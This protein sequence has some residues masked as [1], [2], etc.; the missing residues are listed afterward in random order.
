MPTMSSDITHN[1][2]YVPQFY[3][4]NW[5]SDS[6]HIYEYSLLVPDSRIPY[7]KPSAIRYTAKWNDFYTRVVGDREADDFEKWFN[8]TFENPSKPVFQKILNGEQI[9]REE[10]TI[11]SRYIA[12]QYLRTPAR[13][14]KIITMLQEIMPGILKEVHAKL[15]SAYIPKNDSAPMEYSELLPLSVS[16]D[17]VKRTITTG[18]VIGKSMY[19]YALKHLLTTTLHVMDNY[20]WQVVHAADGISF[21]TSDDPVICLNYFSENEYDF[22]G[23]WGRQHTNIIMPISPEILVFTEVGSYSHAN[24]LDYS[25]QWSRFFRKIIIEHAHRYV[26]A[27]AP[28]KG[29][30]SIHP[31][32]VDRT[33]YL[34]EQEKL[35]NWHH[36][37]LDAE[38]E[39]KRNSSNIQQK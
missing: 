4:Q 14:T 37:Q 25:T 38:L 2:H 22:G 39:L 5:S 35:A 1:N 18:T 19:L 20:S 29:M 21:P 16:I 3:L 23:G 7:W 36:D 24:N 10:S 31:R 6:V 11:L 26:Y 13:A 17:R 28:Q 12:A 8:T 15:D 32:L 30:L 27:I 33:L 9:S 34:Q